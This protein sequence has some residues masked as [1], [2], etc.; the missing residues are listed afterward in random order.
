M[1]G[2]GSSGTAHFSLAVALILA[3]FFP[4]DVN[5]D[6][7]VFG[8]HGCLSVFTYFAEAILMFVV[9]LYLCSLIARIPGLVKV[10]TELGEHTLGILLYHG[11]IASL[12]AAVICPLDNQAWIPSGLTMPQ[13]LIISAATL[14]ICYLICK[15]GPVLLSRIFNEDRKVAGRT[16]EV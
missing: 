14:L 10:L 16:A 7:L 1:E 6:I 12:M 8:S 3:F 5:F 11:F 15:S 9:F 4:P 13:R 2:S